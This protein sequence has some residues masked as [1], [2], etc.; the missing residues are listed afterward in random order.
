MSAEPVHRVRPVAGVRPPVAANVVRT[1]VALAVA[2]AILAAGAGYWQVIEAQRLS[3]APDNP[4]VI[5][6]TRHSLR[7]SILDRNGRW[8][9]V[10]RHD[11]NGE[12]FR[13]YRDASISQVTGYLSRQYGS[14]GLERTYDAALRGVTRADPVADLLKKFDPTPA[15]PLDLRTSLDVR[16]Q[17]LA[18]R[19]LGNDRGAIVMLDPQTGEVLVLA[20]NPTYD[21][22]EIAS[23]D[24]AVAAA[25]FNKLRKASSDPL[26]PRA[27]QGRYVP[28]SVFKIV[29]AIAGL[30]SNR[31]TPETTFP[32][33]AKAEKNG[34]V[35]HGFRIR[36]HPGV[37]AETFHMLEATEWSSNIWYALAGLRIGGDELVQGAAK[38]G[39]GSPIP[40]DLPTA[41]SQV[42]NS[43]GREPGGF[44]DDVELASASFGQGE[45]FV[46][47]LQ[48]ALVAAIVANDGVLMKPR[49]GLQLTGKESGTRT[50]GT[51]Q[52]RRV[53]ST[54]DAVAIQEAMQAA[55][56]S[57]VGR[58]FTSGAGVPGTTTAG[59]SG[60]AQLGG[61]GEPHS[62]FIGFAPVRDPRIAIA[63]IVE[64]GG[65]GGARAAPVAGDMM[66][67]Y[68]DLYGR[69]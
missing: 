26:L 6:V 67:A 41:V 10:T 47:P 30:D 57:D 54:G 13:D 8:L 4:G 45:T 19:A 40:F 15:E 9:A 59:K 51:E 56:E 42:T 55:V 2:F 5:A 69:P 29:T 61:T 48:M 14:A 18:M 7:G 21:A 53:L 37:P 12:T 46:T 38:V 24:P 35:V 68:F 43:D 16:L 32:E 63:V 52:M 60:T 23:P 3:T 64:R 49:L 66:S 62:W 65:R 27:T 17:R 34:L 58:Q 1:G 11:Q 50:I 44:K 31:I 22:S 28:G 25:A 20:S 33:Q 36:E 39:F